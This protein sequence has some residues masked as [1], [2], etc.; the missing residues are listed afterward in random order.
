[1]AFTYPVDPTTSTVIVLGERPLLHRQRLRAR[2][3]AGVAVHRDGHA[4]LLRSRGEVHA[5]G[6]TALMAAWYSDWALRGGGVV[7]APRRRRRRPAARAAE[8][9]SAAAPAVAAGLMWGLRGGA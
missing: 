9:T 3:G 6:P 7:A 2:G 1:M 8:A 4:A 5:L